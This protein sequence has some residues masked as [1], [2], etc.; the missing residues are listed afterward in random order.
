MSG[1]KIAEFFFQAL[2]FLFI[3]LLFLTLGFDTQEQYI[4]RIG[5]GL[6]VLAFY[7]FLFRKSISASLFKNPT[8]LF[9]LLFVL[10]EVIRSLVSPQIGFI[11]FF[12]WVFYFAFFILS[13]SFFKNKK[14]V[15]HLFIV[16]AYSGF[17]LALAII[18]PLF[19]F[20]K[21][22]F[23]YLEPNGEYGFFTKIKSEY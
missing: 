18:P 7:L 2:I 10:F 8:V 5:L 19:H 22:H 17:I 13:F 6:F 23:G 1:K 20:G 21:G 11:P 15:S 4:V 9:F 3:L 16:F 14:H 12:H